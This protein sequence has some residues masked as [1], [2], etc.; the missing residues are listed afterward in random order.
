MNFEVGDVVRWAEDRWVHPWLVLSRTE[1]NARIRRIRQD[2]EGP[3]V[4][5]EKWSAP[6]DLRKDTFLTGFLDALSD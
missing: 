3:E 1:G 5:V 6:S 4:E 2:G